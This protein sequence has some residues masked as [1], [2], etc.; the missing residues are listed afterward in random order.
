MIAIRLKTEYLTCPLGIDIQTPRLFWN[1]E[2]G[3]K[4]TA[5]EIIAQDESAHILFESGK[6]ASGAMRCAWGGAPVPMGTKVFWRIR[7]W[8]ENGLPGE[9]RETFFETG[10]R[11]WTADWI[12]GAYRVNPLKRYPVDCFRKRFH[13]QN[14]QKARLYIT[15]LGV[16]EA[17]INENRCGDF[18]LAPGVTDYTKRVQ[19]QSL[20]V[21][22]L[23]KNG[24]NT[25][26]VFLADGWYRGSCGAWGLKNQY[27][28]QTKLLAQ[29]E[30]TDTSGNI[31]TISTDETWDWSNDGP[32]LFAD[33]Q[34]GE[35]VNAALVPSYNKKAKRTK[36]SV[37]PSASNNVPV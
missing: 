28:V 17:C 16:Y 6:V 12:S 23:L 26:T 1:C 33:N 5:Y 37:L 32:V 20:D 3:Q 19:Y 31:Q 14:I 24:E 27:G 2:G 8:D 34:D 36:H 18:I 11:K 35:I 15:A 29:L 30:I 9:W 10:V 7:L 21:T 13:A 25:L 4:Q 22:A